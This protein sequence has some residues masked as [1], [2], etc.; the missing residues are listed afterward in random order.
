MAHMWR[1]ENNFEESVCNFHLVEA[2]SPV[3]L[4][5]PFFPFCCFIYSKLDTLCPDHDGNQ[6]RPDSKSKATPLLQVQASQELLQCMVEREKL[7]SSFAGLVLKVKLQASLSEP[8]L[9]WVQGVFCSFPSC[10]V[11]LPFVFRARLLRS[12]YHQVAD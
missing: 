11:S 7:K 2:G 9:V 3:V 1:L 6:R 10:S 12:L 4:F 8:F 5:F